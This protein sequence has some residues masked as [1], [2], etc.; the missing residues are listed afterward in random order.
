MRFPI[1]PFVSAFEFLIVMRDIELKEAGMQGP[2]RSEERIA[3]SA[4]EA[5]RGHRIPCGLNV[6]KSGSGLGEE[7]GIFFEEIC[8]LA[9]L[10]N[11]GVSRDSGAER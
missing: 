7:G 2:I 6:G 3:K 1:G 8:E 10:G 4:I 5:E 11:G 9:G